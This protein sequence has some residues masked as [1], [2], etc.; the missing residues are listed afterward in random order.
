MKQFSNEKSF[1]PPHFQKNSS[2]GLI[3]YFGPGNRK[4]GAGFTLVEIL[5]A[6]SIIF[7]LSAILIPGYGMAR[8]QFSLLRSAL[9][10]AQDLRRAQEMATSAKEFEGKIPPGYGIYLERGGKNYLLYADTNPQG[11]NE[12]YDGGDTVVETIGLESKVYIKE[13]LPSS[14]SINF[15][16]PAPIT[17]I[18]GDAN[19]VTITLALETDPTKIQEIFVNKAGLIYVK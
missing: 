16:G 10:L 6:I 7:L 15:R 2:R 1:T 18:S 11:G 8:D 4:N 13:V 9:K 5:V 12:K 17:R 14:L 19:S 3:R